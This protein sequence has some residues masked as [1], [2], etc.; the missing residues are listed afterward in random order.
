ME[1]RISDYSNYE[2]SRSRNGG[3]YAYY[4][5]AKIENYQAVDGN[6]S[7]SAEFDYCPYCGKFEQ[8]LQEHIEQWHPDEQYVP[9]DAMDN[10]VRIL[11]VDG[12]KEALLTDAQAFL[13]EDS[14]IEF[15]VEW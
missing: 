15:A 2:A 13:G 12:D 8:R 6:H 7:T 4:E 14:D 11:C 9:S 1:I 5:T 10:L 3:S